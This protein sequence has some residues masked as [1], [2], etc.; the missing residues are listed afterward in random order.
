MAVDQA[1][2]AL[3]DEGQDAGAIPFN[4]E[5]VLCGIKRNPRLRQ[6]GRHKPGELGDEDRPGHEDPSRDFAE[7][8]ARGL[9]WFLLGRV[10]PLDSSYA[11]P[12][13]L[14]EVDPL[15]SLRC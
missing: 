12:D 2:A 4:L 9:P 6:H 1:A 3:F 11:L 13:G 8:P 14:Y 7:Q 15:R 5:E 10:G